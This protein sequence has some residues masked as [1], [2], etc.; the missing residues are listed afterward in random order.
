MEKEA[1]NKQ[2]EMT[3]K[4]LAE[5]DRAIIEITNALAEQ[6][7]VCIELS[8]LIERAAD[9]K[10]KERLHNGV[11]AISKWLTARISGA[12]SLPLIE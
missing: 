6:L 8:A 11:V 12:I 2:P 10:K 3:D 9:A 4:E 5:E 1:T 7:Q